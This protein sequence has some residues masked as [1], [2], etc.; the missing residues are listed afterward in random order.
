VTTSFNPATG[1]PLVDGNEAVE[2]LTDPELE[3]ELTV[4]SHDP[5]RRAHRFEQLVAEWLRPH[6]ASRRRPQDAQPT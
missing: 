5:V 3:A 2:S 6:R 1:R 4:A